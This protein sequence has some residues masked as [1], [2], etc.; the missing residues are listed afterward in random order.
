M[1]DSLLS[2]LQRFGFDWPW[3]WLLL[4]L[5]L[6][7]AF[8]PPP[9]LEHQQS[10]RVPNLPS[11][12]D[13]APHAG[14]STTGGLRGKTLLAGVIWCCVVCAVSRPHWL[15]PLNLKRFPPGISY[16]CWMYQ[17]PWPRRICRIARV[18]PLPGPR[19]CSRR[20]TTLFTSGK[21]TILA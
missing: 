5:P 3:L 4:P 11:L 9:A 10:V 19:P 1:F 15:A 16:W 12:L 6:L 7:L 18:N 8:M 14:R 21:R 20:S 13:D 17:A 2:I